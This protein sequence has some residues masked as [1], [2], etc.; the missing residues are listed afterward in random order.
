MQAGGVG[1]NI[2]L[3]LAGKQPQTVKQLPVDAFIV[4]T[5]QKRGVGRIG[6]VKVF[7]ALVY[8]AKGKSLGTNMF[9]P[10]IDGSVA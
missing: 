6:P 7:S 9:P 5:G 4:A 1:K 8:M 3:V 2:Q 10:Y